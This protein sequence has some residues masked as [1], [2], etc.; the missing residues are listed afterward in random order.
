MLL[1]VLKVNKCVEMISFVDGLGNIYKHMNRFRAPQRTG[2]Y[3]ILYKFLISTH[4]SNFQGGFFLPLTSF[5]GCNLH[6]RESHVTGH[7]VVSNNKRKAEVSHDLSDNNKSCPIPEKSDWVNSQLTLSRG[8]SLVLVRVLLVLVNL[9][10]ML[11]CQENQVLRM[12]LQQ[13]LYFSLSLL[14]SMSLSVSARSSILYNSFP[15]TTRLTDIGLAV[16]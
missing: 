12:M 8:S 14:T 4:R 2:N 7:S 16:D 6:A 13:G 15:T 11:G 5:Q 3:G 1:I 9:C 10:L